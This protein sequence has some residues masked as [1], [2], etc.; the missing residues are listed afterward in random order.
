MI[1]E[2]RLCHKCH[3]LVPADEPVTI[4]GRDLCKRCIVKRATVKNPDPVPAAKGGRGFPPFPGRCGICGGKTGRAGEAVCSLCHRR[5]Y[6]K[7]KH[8][9]KSRHDERG[10]KLKSCAAEKDM[11][12]LG[13]G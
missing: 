8:G 5:Y 9:R 13:R 1:P 10:R 7:V 2:K 3:L 12:L 4:E 11:P 6:G